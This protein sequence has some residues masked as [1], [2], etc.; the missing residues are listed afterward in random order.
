MKEI[1]ETPTD[2]SAD[3]PSNVVAVLAGPEVPVNVPL[4]NPSIVCVADVPMAFR[5]TD[6]P[7]AVIAF[8]AAR[9][10]NANVD[11]TGPEVVVPPPPPPPHPASKE[12]NRATPNS[13]LSFM[14]V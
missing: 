4:H 8:T 11:A 3:A 9:K 2:E 13:D 7:L 5:V 10:G 1:V 14:V 6:S 12:V